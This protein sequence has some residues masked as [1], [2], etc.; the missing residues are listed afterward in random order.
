MKKNSLQIQTV[1]YQNSQESL[2]RSMQSI[3]NAIRVSHNNGIA[4]SDV[5]LCYG[6]ASPNQLLDDETIVALQTKYKNYFNFSYQHFGFNAGSAR[7]HN[8]L[9]MNCDAEY[10]LLMNPDILFSPRFLIEIIYPFDNI[11]NVGIAE[12]RQTPIE[13]PKEYHSSTGETS[14]SSGACTLIKSEF[15]HQI[16]GYD[17]ESFFMYCDDVDLSW[18]VRLLG[19][20]VIYQ[21]HAVVFHAKR[22]S[23]KGHMQPTQ[24]ETYNSIQAALYMYHKWSNKN[25]LSN[26]LK[27]LSHSTDKNIIK[28]VN[29]FTVREKK[30]ELQLPMKNAH[31]VATFVNDN[32]TTHRFIL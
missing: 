24:T 28:I 7:G 22:L 8:L 2:I 4:F 29:D 15:F 27:T 12:G 11:K 32:Y 13:H 10:M 1:L 6:D 5:R 14:W 17:A 21:P 25:Q 23:E 30:G 18:R 31:R 26:L 3:Q 20:K 19:K 9:G 16:G